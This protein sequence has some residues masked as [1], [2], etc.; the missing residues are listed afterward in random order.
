M[1]QFW[2]KLRIYNEAKARV[3]YEVSESAAQAGKMFKSRSGKRENKGKCG[4]IMT[5]EENKVSIEHLLNDS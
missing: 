2:W 1:Y 3:V 4:K 5:Q